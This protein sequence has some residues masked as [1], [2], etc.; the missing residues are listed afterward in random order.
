MKYAKRHRR[1]VVFG[2]GRFVPDILWH[3]FCRFLAF[4]SPISEAPNS[5]KI[6][7]IR[8]AGVG[9]RPG[10]LKSVWQA[11]DIDPKW[12]KML[13]NEVPGRSWGGLG[14]VF[15]GPRDDLS[16]NNDPGRHFGVLARFRRPFWASKWSPEWSKNDQKSR[17]FSG[18][19]F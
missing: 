9:Y 8:V 19:V 6:L 10:G 13:Q 16:K 2:F 17:P 1:P 7:T 4:G 11:W 14:R 15:G 3:G 5:S 12:H 18:P